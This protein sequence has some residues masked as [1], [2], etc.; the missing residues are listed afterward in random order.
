MDNRQLKGLKSRK[1]FL[2]LPSLFIISLLFKPLI[3]SWRYIV[4]KNELNDATTLVVKCTRC[5]TQ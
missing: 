5:T 1:F 4:T 2:D 3:A